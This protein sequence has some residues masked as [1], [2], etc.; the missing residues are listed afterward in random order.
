[1]EHVACYV[2]ECWPMK[3]LWPDMTI[4]NITCYIKKNKK[5]I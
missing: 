5:I 2:R 4:A 3:I 1:M